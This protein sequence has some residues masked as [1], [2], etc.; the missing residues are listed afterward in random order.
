MP[1]QSPSI[2]QAVSTFFISFR[3]SM[4]VLT[5]S[6]K[7]YIQALLLQCTWT[8]TFLRYVF[9]FYLYRYPTLTV[10]TSTP[11]SRLHP[12][13][14]VHPSHLSLP[15]PIALF[16]TSVRL[17]ISIPRYRLFSTSVDSSLV[18]SSIP[19]PVR[20]LSLAL[21]HTLR[22]SLPSALVVITHLPSTSL[23][24]FFSLYLLPLFATSSSLRT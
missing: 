16:L 12:T 4:P 21:Q 18:Q 10:I 8:T 23:R 24:P 2:S 6:S 7:I 1:I 13:Y 5:S 14:L 19:L 9:Y 17:L 11:S 15:P 3:T 20:P 22:S